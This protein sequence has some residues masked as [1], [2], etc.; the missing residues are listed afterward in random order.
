MIE[1]SLHESHF[2]T[3][4]RYARLETMNTTDCLFCKIVAGEIPATK[5]YEDEFTLAFLDIVPVNPG[6][7]LVI[8]KKHYE[9]IFAAPEETLVQMMKT[10]KKVAHGIKDGLH[11]D[12]MNIGMNNGTH[13]GQTVYHA[14]IHLMPRKQGDGYGLWHGKKYPDGE[15]AKIAEQIKGAL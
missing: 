2:N 10:I 7:T 5:I 6:H 9:N 8:P 1:Y 12:D 3:Q 15:A 11:I 14:H 13:S 4:G